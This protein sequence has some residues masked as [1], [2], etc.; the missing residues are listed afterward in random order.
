MASHRSCAVRFAAVHATGWALVAPAAGQAATAP[1][2]K[3][4]P[5]G[6]QKVELQSEG[7]D[8][9]F[10]LYVPASYDG[11]TAMPLLINLHPTGSNGNK[12]LGE[13]GLRARADA[14]GFLIAAPNGGAISGSGFTWVV[15]GTPPRGTAPPGGFPDDVVHL[16]DVIA[17]V[18]SMACQDPARVFAAG[19]SGGARMTS[20]LACYA[21]DTITA[22]VADAGLR[23][24]APKYAADGT[25]VPEP[26]PETCKPARP[27]PVIALH[28]TAD[29]T[30]PFDGGGSPDWQYSVPQALSRWAELLGCAPEPATTAR[31]PQVDEVAY[32]GCRGYAALRLFRVNGGGHVWFSDPAQFQA[33]AVVEDVIA[34]YALAAP[35]ISPIRVTCVRGKPRIRIT[36]T[37]DSP[38]A[39]LVVVANGKRVANTSGAVVDK[40]VTPGPGKRL[41]TIVLVADKAGLTAARTRRTASCPRPKPAS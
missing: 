22:V 35:A 10:L 19:F 5:P 20:A 17:K 30:N 26:D 37:T 28:G 34:Q 14:G 15:P 3:P 11:T 8:R 18:Q 7:R 12:H 32:G 33:D 36:A 31:A 39:S 9:A 40:R 2:S 16:R 41:K 21:A 13:T 27:L 4:L 29:G 23:T 38:L 1:C 6:N 24:G 25:P